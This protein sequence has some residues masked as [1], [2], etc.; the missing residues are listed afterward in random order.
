A[1]GGGRTGAVGRAGGVR[2]APGAG[3]GAPAGR[4]T[5]NGGRGRRPGGRGRR[6]SRR[7]G[8]GRRGRHGDRDR[9]GQALVGGDVEGQGRLGRPRVRVVGQLD[10]VADR[11]RVPHA[12]RGDG[13][14]VARDG[15]ERGLGV[16]VLG[17]GV[18]AGPVGVVGDDPAR[19]A[20][21]GRVADGV[22]DLPVTV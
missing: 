1:P 7:R 6:G 22:V 18:V 17:R 12:G 2:G 21:V 8:G 15:V 13:Q 9:A 11:R 20:A 14:R 3:G 16:A 10:P 5:R 4:G 19:H